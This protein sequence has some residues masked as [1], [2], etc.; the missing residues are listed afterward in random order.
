MVGLGLSVRW[1]KCDPADATLEVKVEWDVRVAMTLIP[2]HQ[3]N[4]KLVSIEDDALPVTLS[5]VAR[6][7][8]QNAV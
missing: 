3:K 2:K 4:N 6:L 5:M 8:S 7:R 1:S